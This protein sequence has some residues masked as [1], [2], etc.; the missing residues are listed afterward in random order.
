VFIHT[1]SSS[2]TVVDKYLS[3]YAN[4]TS[5]FFLIIGLAAAFLGLWYFSGSG[6]SGRLGV[7]S[8]SVLSPSFNL[9]VQ[10]MQSVSG[11]SISPHPVVQVIGTDGSGLPGVK[12]V[13]R[14]NSGDFAEESRTELVTDASG[15]ATFSELLIDPSQP[16]YVVRFIAEDFGEVATKE[17][18]V[19]FGPP[20]KMT[21]LNEPLDSLVGQTIEG[22]PSVLVTDMAGNPVRGVNVMVSAK[23]AEPFVLEGSKVAQT[24][25]AGIAIFDDL[26]SPNPASNCRLHF[27]PAVAGVNSV[28]SQTFNIHSRP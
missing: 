20:R 12:V 18:N 16:S 7:G 19:R 11:E 5:L 14:L 9:L 21:V 25:N 13:A 17:F 22:S 24:D 2:K 27:D 3:G 6:E 4:L 10:P 1:H 23:T 8:P 26:V 28:E 15:I